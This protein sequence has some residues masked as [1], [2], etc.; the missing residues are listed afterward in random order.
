MKPLR[1]FLKSLTVILLSTLLSF[2][3]LEAVLRLSG[4]IYLSIQDQKNARRFAD[5]QAITVLCVGESTT[6][7]GGDESYPRQLEIIL[8]NDNPR[9][10]YSVLNK[11]IPAIDTTDIIKHLPQ[12]L[13]EYQPDILVTMMG[14]NDNYELVQFQSEPLWLKRFKNFR[15]VKLIKWIRENLNATKRQADESSAPSTSIVPH[16]NQIPIRYQL[17]YI[18]ALRLMQDQKFSQAEIIW[19]QLVNLN[20]NSEFT[21][22]ARQQLASSFLKQQKYDEFL[23]T[24]KIFLTDNPYDFYASESI[25]SVCKSQQG[26]HAITPLLTELMDIHP[27]NS[28]ILY[29]ME[30]CHAKLNDKSILGPLV[31]HYKTIHQQSYDPITK[32]NYKC[33]INLVQTR[34]IPL[35]IMQ[36]PLRSI[37]HL[38]QMLETIPLGPNIIFLEN[39]QNFAQALKTQSFEDLFNDHFAGDFGHA[40]AQ[41]NRLIAQNLAQKILA[42]FPVHPQK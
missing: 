30:A 9:Y 40:T 24:L 38:Q 37:N 22:G 18:H 14:I 17:A 42:Q 33:L 8:N 5:R 36:Y 31:H 26:A 39:K 34:G 13:D 12:W 19:N 29:L 20:L 41:G 2:I 6:A 27:N 35:V 28:R 32:E 21:F 15:V 16:S 10:H 4:A 11:G 1:G 7:M 23:R 25:L 3:I